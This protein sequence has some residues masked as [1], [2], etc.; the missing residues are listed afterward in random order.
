M[1]NEAVS[2]QFSQLKVA[3]L[4]FLSSLLCSSTYTDIL[5]M[6]KS[7]PEDRESADDVKTVLK[8]VMKMMTQK[9]VLFNPI[10]E[11]RISSHLLSL[12]NYYFYYV[13]LIV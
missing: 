11:Q 8:S 12:C 7:A 3:S 10:R 5:V 9:A 6:P 2:M 13:R 4:R 1:F